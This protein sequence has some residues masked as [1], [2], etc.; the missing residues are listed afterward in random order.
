MIDTRPIGCD[1]VVVGGGIIGLT[2]A[3]EIRRR[4]SDASVVLLEKENECGQHA[5]GRNSGVLHAGFYYTSDSLK[6]RFSRIGNRE[7]SEYCRDRNLLLNE[8][9]KLVVTRDEDELDL[10][11]DLFRR[12]AANGVPVE[13]IDADD[14]W[15]L[16][17]EARTVGAA[18][19][20]PTTSS[21]EPRQV[22][23]SL[24]RDASVLG[25]RIETRNAFL[26]HVGDEILTTR[27]KLTA[28]YLINAA[29]LY[30]DT[31]AHDYGFGEEYGIL[32][33]RGLYLKY[34][35]HGPVPRRHIYPVPALENPF[36]GVHWT[37]SA[38]GGVKI[39]PTAIPALWREHYRGL[40]NLRFAEMLEIGIRESDMWL[41]DSSGFRRLARMELRKHGKHRLLKLAR[42]LVAPTT[43]TGDWSWGNPGVRAQLINTRTRQLEMDFIYMGDDRSFHV[44]NAVSPAFTCAFPFARHV[45]DEVESLVGD[46]GPASPARAA[47]LTSVDASHIWAGSGCV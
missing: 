38:D 27:G 2:V 35:G 9:G 14:L 3:M 32:P 46:G 15:R 18:L 31:I 43:G 20:S 12:A 4:W 29:G 25:V 26:G 22:I 5:S 36:L 34:V 33:F 7:L 11:A 19:Y 42:R 44:L 24:V 6:A 47:G 8:C 23:G 37:T 17:P 28:G 30:A 41:R 13:R 1:F 40:A 21:V 16:E 39:G 45:A 10:L